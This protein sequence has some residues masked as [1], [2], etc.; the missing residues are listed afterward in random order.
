LTYGLTGNVTKSALWSPAAD[1]VRWL[2]AQGLPFR[3]DPDLAAGLAERGLVEA[4]VL[5][6]AADAAFARTSDL[7][8]SFG[9]DGTLLRTAHAVGP[10]CTPILGVNIGRLGFL[11]DIE[12]Q[13]I[14]QAIAAVEAGHYH[15]ENRAILAAH[16]DG[17]PFA[18]PWAV[19]EFSFERYGRAGLISVRVTVD[20]A[21]LNTY[22]GDGLIVATPTG[23]TAYS[24]S[25]GGPIVYPTAGVV[26]LSPVAPHT[27]TVRPVVLPD[28]VRIEATVKTRGTPF[29]V[30]IDGTAHVVEAPAESFVIERASHDLRLVRLDGQH[31]FNTL[32]EKLMWGQM[33]KDA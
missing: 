30:A 21:Y 13:E 15:V 32:R 9:G 24:L 16:H 8:L 26:V 29:V 14:Q 28:T 3:L 12:T 11:A 17:L 4:E 7:V 18:T 2:N 20:G 1:L 31:F 22:W 19:N 6:G 33:A 10:A 5:N 25:V 23:S 27:L